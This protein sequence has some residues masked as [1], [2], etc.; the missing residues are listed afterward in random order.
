MVFVGLIGLVIALVALV[1]GRMRWARI[2]NRTMAAGA[3]A[4]AFAAVI[5][6]AAVIVEI[7]PA[8]ETGCTPV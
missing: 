4:E 5:V 8:D 3:L 1:R 7:V 6:G 2:A